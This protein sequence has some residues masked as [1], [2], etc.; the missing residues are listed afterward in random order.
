[1]KIS[2][3][4][5]S[6]VISFLVFSFASLTH[7]GSDLQS[8]EGFWVYGFEQSIFE[9][10]DGAVYWMWVPHEF[11]GKYKQEGFRNYV[12]VKGYLKPPDP[13]NNMYSTLPSLQIVEIK[14]AREL[15]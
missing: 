13:E 2:R 15:C 9:S 12:R 8:F 7:A 3:S 4:I 1:M 11:I 6:L 10:C 14:R 5:H